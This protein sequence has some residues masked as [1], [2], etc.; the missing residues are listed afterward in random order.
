MPEGVKRNV[1]GGHQDLTW[2]R[3]TLPRRP[4]YGCRVNTRIRS[5]FESGS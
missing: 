1:F 4:V 3:A 2:T 5:S